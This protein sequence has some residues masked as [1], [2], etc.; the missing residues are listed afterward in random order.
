MTREQLLALG[1][2]EEQVNQI[3]ALH[4]QATQG[5]RATI[6]SNTATITKLTTDLE[7]ALKAKPE[8]PKEPE[9]QVVDPKLAEALEKVAQL[10]SE[11]R[12]KDIAVYAGGKNLTGENAEKILAA[13]GDNVELAKAAIDAIGQV[14]SDT[15]K[16]ARDAEKQALLNNTPNPGGNPTNPPDAKTD[17]VKNAENITFGANAAEQTAKDYYVMK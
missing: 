17:D 2:T 8:T 11:M 10:E 15:D 6:E 13:F 3:M 7:T 1:Y 12:K 9:P 4:G 16:S 14:I 5:L